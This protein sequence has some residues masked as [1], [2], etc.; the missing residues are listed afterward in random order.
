MSKMIK[1]YDYVIIGAGIYGLYAAELLSRKKYK[2]AVLELEADTFTRASYINQ[3]RV[4]YGYHYPRSYA[5]AIKS[6]GYFEKFCRDF[7]F[8]INNKFKK[9]YAISSIYSLTSGQQFAKFCERAGIKC[10]EINPEPFFTAG[11]VENAFETEEYAFDARKI[12]CYFNKI[13]RS[14]KNIDLFFQ[15]KITEVATKSAS[16][17]LNTSNRETIQTRNVINTTYA[18]TNQILK[19]FNFKLL[20]VKYEICEVILCDISPNL[21]QVGLTVMDGP[22]FSLM[23]FGLGKYHSLTSVTFT[24]HLTSY[25]KLPEFSCQLVNKSC[26]QDD[27]KNCN[28]CPAKPKSAW[29]LMS[30]LAKKYLKPELEYKYVKSLFAIKPILLASET[31]DSRPT[32]IEKLA[33]KPNFTTILS[34][35]INTIYD[36][37]KILC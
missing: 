1:Q 19:L 23:P 36:L 31:D 6:A 3:A 14:R 10:Q 20:P 16:Y 4:H 32:L 22:F 26:T 24:P 28:D 5:T 21:K 11:Q 9:I 17:I 25:N 27:L 34:G 18:S 12:K 35:K 30:Q 37:D 15:T 33:A 8:A 7:N 29:P 2:I 13:L